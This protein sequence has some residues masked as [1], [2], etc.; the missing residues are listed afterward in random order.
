MN[1]RLSKMED[2][3]HILIL[4][5]RKSCTLNSKALQLELAE[6]NAHLTAELGIVVEARD[7]ECRRLGGPVDP[8]YWD[9]VFRLQGS[10]L[11]V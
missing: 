4:T 9:L 7:G 10:V 1:L 8:V 6:T 11:R 5:P 2:V 3:A